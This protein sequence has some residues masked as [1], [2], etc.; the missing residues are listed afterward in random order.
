MISVKLP[1]HLIKL[2]CYATFKDV[3]GAAGFKDEVQK[4]VSTL[5][6][7]T[8]KACSNET[9]FLVRTTVI[10]LANINNIICTK[11]R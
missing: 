5:E 9:T 10:I 8:I 2:H 6:S 11:G 3:S 1:K 7:G 4:L